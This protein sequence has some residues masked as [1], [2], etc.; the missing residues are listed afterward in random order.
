M[1]T[2]DGL[3]AMARLAREAKHRSVSVS[4]LVRQAIEDCYPGGG[5]EERRTALDA[6]SRAP[7]MEVPSPGVLRREREA[8][9][10]R[11][12]L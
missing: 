11:R 6:V 5:S 12:A 4:T 9:S 10:A 7:L 3:R 8:I 2:D 1:F